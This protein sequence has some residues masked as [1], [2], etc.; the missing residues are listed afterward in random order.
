MSVSLKLGVVL[1][2]LFALAVILFAAL[3]NDGTARST[4][5]G[6]LDW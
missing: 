1:A 2:I 3:S 4:D 6:G 5:G